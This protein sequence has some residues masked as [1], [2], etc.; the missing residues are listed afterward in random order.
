MNEDIQKQ[1]IQDLVVESTE[2]LDQFDRDLLSL[3]NKEGDEETLHRIF[4]TIHTIK[5]SSGC[6]GLR[7][8]ERV[9]H[10]GENLLSLLRDGRLVPSPPL[11]NS[12]FRY[13]DALRQMFTHLSASSVEPDDD[14]SSLLADLNALQVASAGA[15][16]HMQAGSSGL[17]EDEEAPFE[18]PSSAPL[19][20]LSSAHVD[21]E[22]QRAP[23]DLSH[24]PPAAPPSLPSAAAPVVAAAPS[25]DRAPAA[26]SPAASASDAAIR[27]DVGQLDILMDLVGELVLARNQIVQYAGDL[28]EPVLLNSTQRL[29]IITS[30]L[31]ENVM[32]TR[33]QPIGNVWGKFPRVVRD[34]SVE[35]GKRVSLLMEGSETEMDRTI[36]EAI[37]D[38]LTHVIRNAIDHGLETPDRRMAAGKAAEGQL[39]MRAFHEGGQVIIEISDDGSGIDRDRVTRKAVDRGL[40]GGEQAARLTDREVFSLIFLPGFSTAEQV[41]SISGRGVGM[42]VVKKNIERIGG[43]VDVESERGRSTTIR[44]RIPLTLAII[45]ALIVRCAGNRYAIPQASLV[46]LVRIDA[47]QAT[48]AVEYVGGYPVYR[49]RGNLL[50]LVDLRD[51]LQLES[52]ASAV[53]ESIFLL[54][55]QAEGRQFGLVVDSILDTEE[56]VVKPLGK[57]LK[58]VTTYAGATIMGDGRVALILDIIGIARRAKLLEEGTG[59]SLDA[60]KTDAAARHSQDRQTLLLISIDAGRQAAIPLSSVSRLEEFARSAVEFAGNSEVVQYRGEIMPLL[61][62]DR[63]LNGA[64]AATPAT[65][66]PLKVV[67]YSLEGRSFGLVVDRILDIVS[68]EVALQRCRNRPGLLGSAVVL[69]RVT[70]FIDIPAL[71]ARSG[72]ADFDSLHIC[73]SA[74]G[75]LTAPASHPSPTYGATEECYA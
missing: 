67:V 60:G 13:S 37:K 46:E 49:L 53:S 62:L 58:K 7:R 55:L 4:R 48:K 72:V 29:S 36:L 63:L 21:P 59:R 24:A 43:T 20:G 10:T 11:I 9:A 14:H 73:A 8:I 6:L 12:L 56:I 39:K 47:D 15:E 2:G 31:Q 18:A 69:D 54:V 5:G 22:S 32:K 45:P 66:D 25:A 16:A 17:F 51:Q 61:P 75:G 65:D 50:P 40:I 30:K 34:L 33:M 44:I 3:E 70:D 35:L 41:T 28:R 64:V 38:P 23:E 52:R 71:I 26:G 74:A 1:L 19:P 42:D 57:E 68:Y 27:V